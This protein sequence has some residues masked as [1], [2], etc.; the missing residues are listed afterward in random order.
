VE[1]FVI[2][3][4]E[5]HMIQG[6]REPQVGSRARPYVTKW[7]IPLLLLYDMLVLVKCLSIQKNI[8]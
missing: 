3:I 5:Q 4:E 6:A 7:A 1:R 8:F 2:A